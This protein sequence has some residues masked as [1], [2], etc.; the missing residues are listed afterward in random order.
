[1]NFITCLASLE[2]RLGGG[3]E[4]ESRAK[5]LSIAGL[6]VSGVVALAVMI[7]LTGFPVMWEKLNDVLVLLDGGWRVWNGQVPHRDFYS[8]IGPYPLGVFA[9]GFALRGSDVSGLPLA[10][11]CVGV[12]MSAISWRATQGR[13]T[14]WW[15]LAVAFQTLLLPVAVTFLGGGTDIGGGEGPPFGFAFH[16]SYAMQYN[17]MG[18]AALLNQMLIMLLPR[19]SAETTRQM[20]GDAV[21]AGMMVALCVFCKIN[22]LL[23]TGFL[24]VWWLYSSE[25]RARRAAALLAG[26]LLISVLLAIKPGGVL[27][28]FV[29][30]WRLLHVS[31]TES[32]VQSLLVRLRANW[33][34]LLI[35]VGGHISLLVE[36]KRR[37]ASVQV[38]WGW[39]PMNFF[40]ALGVSLFVTTFNTQRG[41]VPGFLVAGLITV[42]MALRAMAQ[43]P[44][45]AAP[46]K[47]EA[48]L[49]KCLVAKALCAVFVMSGICYDWGSL[50]YAALWK[51]RKPDWAKESERLPGMLSVI[52]I[53]VYFNEPT[54]NSEVDKAITR[55]RSG[56]WA[57]TGTD[58]FMTSRQTARWVEDGMELLAK[59]AGPADRIFV[60]A[61]FNPFNLGLRIPP[62][63]GGGM[64][65][66]Y[67]RVVD[68]H[69]HPDVQRTLS[70]VT[71]F[72]VP[73]RADWLEQREYMVRMYGQGLGTDFH[74]VGES[75]FWV[76]WKR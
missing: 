47:R 4:P 35:L 75:T 71:I 32:H 64:H 41:E 26:F 66:D 27:A 11:L 51:I 46:E 13:L 43:D 22:F 33:S 67:D 60:A 23:G 38:G 10:L 1:M 3:G 5:R 58:N 48:L 54:E 59:N 2:H 24:C 39:L 57:N 17:R 52:P 21:L 45:G 34:W 8:V 40:V 31:R 68:T 37:Q 28:Y 56:P 65:W 69:I 50:A 36:C 55:R 63:S 44:M 61:W 20:V 30:Q 6:W 9:L 62:A 16:T 74:A 42:E 12:V 76:C 70:E 29:D 53:P 19:R 15:R 72:M 49:T 18:W 73:K 7:W 25:Q 14:L